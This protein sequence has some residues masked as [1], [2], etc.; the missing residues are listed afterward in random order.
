MAHVWIPVPHRRYVD[1]RLPAVGE[2]PVRLLGE[3]RDPLLVPSLALLLVLDFHTMPTLRFIPPCSPIRAPKPP[4]GEVWLHELKLD[5]YRLQIVKD[6]REV[7]LFTR[8][9]TS[10]RNAL[11]AFADPFVALASDRRYS[12]A[13]S[14]CQTRP[15]RQTFAGCTAPW[16]R[17]ATTSSVFFAFDLLHRDGQDL[18]PLP[19]I[20]RRQRP[21]D[22]AA[23]IE[24]TLPQP[25]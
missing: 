15:D 18:R 25:A 11:R 21:R 9:G 6:R 17:L 22:P 12:T 19:L 7:R 5:G 24:D 23:P 1:A 16:H 3:R 8:R 14:C 13:N 10:G 4:S 2:L 20:E